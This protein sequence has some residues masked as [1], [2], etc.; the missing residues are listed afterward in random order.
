MYLA[1]S[2]HQVSYATLPSCHRHVAVYKGKR[3][4]QG[5]Q[6]GSMMN[7]MRRMDMHKQQ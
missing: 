7:M 4:R 6:C 5:Y 2:T 3:Q 1:S